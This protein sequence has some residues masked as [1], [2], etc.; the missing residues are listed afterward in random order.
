MNELFFWFGMRGGG[1][2]VLR[3]LLFFFLIEMCRIIVVYVYF[4]LILRGIL[5]G[6]GYM[7][8]KG[9]MLIFVLEYV[10]IYGV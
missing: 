2:L 7:N 10:Y 5:G 6:N 1:R 4:I 9:I 8:L 3:F